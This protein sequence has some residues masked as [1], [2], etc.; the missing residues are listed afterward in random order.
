MFAVLLLLTACTPSGISY[1]PPPR[2]ASGPVSVERT[3]CPPPAAGPAQRL[4]SGAEV[5]VLAK[6]G[7][8]EVTAEDVARELFKTHRSE[9]FAAL[10]RIVVREILEREATRI[11][12]LVPDSVVEED[13]KRALEDLKVQAL[14]SYGA[15]TTPERYLEIERKQS[16]KDWL[17]QKDAESAERFL[18][19][20]IIRFHA[21]QSDRVELILITLDDEKTAREV[22]QKLD[23][24]ADFSQL[25]MSYST[26]PTGR[27]GGR[28]PPMARE[29]LNPSVADRAFALAPGERTSILSVDDGLGRRQFEIV[30][31][32]R[33]LP[34][35]SVRWPEVVTEV[36]EG[37][38]REPVS[39]DEFIA[40]NLRLERLYGVWVDP[41][42]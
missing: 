31:V 25:A 4:G 24:G 30:K 28:L 17:R 1:V 2:M 36:E 10:N 27:S 12:L 33:R 6:V 9:A 41:G 39:R 14:K 29:S 22:V 11:G 8:R 42:L 16:L 20:R 3:V 34:G 35:R 32:V 37:I 40:W 13:R 38:K 7:G 5:A 21:I 19:A 23:Q 26:H 15:G 18:L